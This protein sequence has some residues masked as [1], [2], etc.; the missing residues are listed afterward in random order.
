MAR[1]HWTRAHRQIIRW[2]KKK[3]KRKLKEKIKTPQKPLLFIP[4]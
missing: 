4:F 1:L 3:E 2:I